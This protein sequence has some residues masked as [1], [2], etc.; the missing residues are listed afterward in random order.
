MLRLNTP[1]ESLIIHLQSAGD[2][3]YNI[4]YKIVRNG[5][6]SYESREGILTSSGDNQVLLNDYSSGHFEITYLNI[7]NINAS[8]NYISLLKQ[9]Q[10][11]QYE[12]MS[13]SIALQYRDSVLYTSEAGYRVLDQNGQFKTITSS[14]CADADIE[15]SD[16]TYTA[17]APSGGTLVLPNSN[18]T[19]NTNPEGNIVSVKTIDIV[20]NDGTNPVTPDVINIVGNTITLELPPIGDV[21]VENSDASYSVVEPSGGILTL[22]DSEIFVNTI[23]QGNVVSVKNIN[24]SLTDGTNPVVPISINLS[25]NTLT[26]T[27][28]LLVV[29]IEVN[30]IP[31][32]TVPAP[33]TIDIPVINTGAAAVGAISGTDVVIADSAITITDSALT[34]LYTVNVPAEAP[35]NQAI[36]DAT[37]ENS[38]ASYSTSVLA[39]GSLTLPDT[40]VNVNGD[41]EGDIVSVKTIDIDLTDGVSPVTPV[42]ITITG[43][44]IDIEL[45]PVVAPSGVAFDFIYLEQWTEYRLGDEGWRTQSGWNTYSPPAYPKVIAQLDTTLGANMYFRLKDNL[46][47]GGVSSKIRFVD[48]LGGQTFAS[49]N[50]RNLVGID[51]LTGMMFTRTDLGSSVNWNNN[52]DNALT[53]S[54]VVDGVTYD[55][56]VLIS[57]PESIK[58]FNSLFKSNQTDPISSA[59]IVA[60]ANAITHTSST[61]PDSTG[62]S[63]AARFDTANGQT[64]SQYNKSSNGRQIYVR[65]CQSLIT[66]P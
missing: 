29:D 31:Y 58:M 42:N 64:I 3:H 66:A 6:E 2:I 45:D 21:T 8:T 27:L 18:V 59:A 7:T 43:N 65:K 52:I 16:A 15:N 4:T 35:L 62:F 28:A 53:H 10:V 47:V 55:D 34:P 12:L 38:D 33:G 36:T 44:T 5:R 23:S 39:E 17:S 19:V 25:G 1:V 46:V 13:Q 24:V 57:M 50:N 37:V 63:N 60:W 61:T 20:I 32:Q 51:K 48:V 30:G 54:I 49:T 41:D 40:Q 22:P 9:T 26:I 14:V 56:W 11:G